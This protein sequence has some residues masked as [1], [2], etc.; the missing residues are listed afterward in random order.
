MPLRR[1]GA[2]RF[3]PSGAALGMRKGR[4]KQAQPPITLALRFSA[5]HNVRAGLD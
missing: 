1:H 5:M 3:C 2:D 4:G